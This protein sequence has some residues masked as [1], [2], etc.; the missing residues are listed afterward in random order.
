MKYYL[1]KF[2]L[3]SQMLIRFICIYIVNVILSADA[4][5]INNLINRRVACR[6]LNGELGECT[7]MSSCSWVKWDRAKQRQYACFRNL[8]T[9]RVCCPPKKASMV[10]NN[11]KS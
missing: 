4:Q 6:S 3:I 1:I 9:I 8:L 11:G 2:D 7:S 5:Y 10:K